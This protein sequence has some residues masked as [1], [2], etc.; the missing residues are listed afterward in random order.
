MM[1]VEVTRVKAKMK[2]IIMRTVHQ[3]WKLS[4]Q[5]R[6]NAHLGLDMRNFQPNST[7]TYPNST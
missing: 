4:N 1:A 6:K 7:T 2:K 3:K 5:K